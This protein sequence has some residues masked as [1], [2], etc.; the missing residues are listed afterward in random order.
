MSLAGMKDSLCI[1]LNE[2]LEKDAIKES[3]FLGD[4][5]ITKVDKV[6]IEK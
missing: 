3:V 1:D 2:L 6:S 4:R 5:Y